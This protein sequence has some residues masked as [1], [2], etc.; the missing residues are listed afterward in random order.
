MIINGHKCR[1]DIPAAPMTL[2]LLRSHVEL[3][4]AAPLEVHLFQK[5]ASKTTVER[6]EERQ[7]LKSMVVAEEQSVRNQLIM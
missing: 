5:N 4:P 7:S 3:P 2:I 1:P 6:K